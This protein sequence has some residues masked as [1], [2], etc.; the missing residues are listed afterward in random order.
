MLSHRFAATLLALPVLA[1]SLHAADAPLPALQVGAEEGT[2]VFKVK[3]TYSQPLAAF[4]IEVVD[5]TDVAYTFTRD[6]TGPNAIAAGTEKTIKV[7][8]PGPGTVP[9][10][11]KI[12]AAVYEDGSTAGAAEKVNHILDLRRT[13]LESTREII[14]RI[15]KDQKEGKDKDAIVAD[16]RQWATTVVPPPPYG[17]RPVTDPKKTILR[18]MIV[19]ASG[20]VNTKGIAEEL[21]TLKKTESELAASKP[22]L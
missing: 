11:V 7:A 21:T 18:N 6:E 2:S 1:I 15:E 13:R 3:N 19:V 20:Q 5:Y 10:H 16:L 4:L 17:T 22:A 8:N 14:Q 12:T 9:D